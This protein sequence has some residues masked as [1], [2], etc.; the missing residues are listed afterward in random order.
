MKFSDFMQIENDTVVFVKSGRRVALQDIC[1]S[2]V[3]IHPVLKKAGATV[4]NALTNAVTSSIANANEQVDII[5]RVQLK[6]GYEDIQMNNQVLIRGNME[7]HNMVEHARKLQKKLK[8]H[9][10]L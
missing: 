8:E 3:R 4:A 5:L 9:I 2:E 7:Y 1:S 6:D 10:A